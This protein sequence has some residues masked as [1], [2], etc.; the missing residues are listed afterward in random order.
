MIQITE[1][2]NVWIF[3]YSGFSI[4]LELFC[5]IGKHQCVEIDARLE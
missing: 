4:Y 3:H 5:E 2:N 1:V